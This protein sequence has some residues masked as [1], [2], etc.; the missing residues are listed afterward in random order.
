M[1]LVRMSTV[2]PSFVD[3]EI[4]LYAPDGAQLKKGLDMVSP[5]AAEI[6]SD[7]LPVSGRYTVLA[8]D[9]SS[10][11][12]GDYQIYTQ[13]LNNPQ[14]AT[15]IGFGEA[16]PGSIDF[17]VKADTYTFDALEGDVVLVRMTTVDPSQ[18]DAEIVLYAPDGSQLKNGLDMVSP[19]AAEITSSPLPASGRYTVLARDYSSDDTG[20]YEIYIQRLNNPQVTSPIGFGEVLAGSLEFAV[21]ADSYTFD[22]LEGDVVLARMTTVS[23]SPVD[24]EILLYAPNGSLLKKS[25]DM[26]SPGAAEITSDPLP[27]N[28]RYTV[29]ARDYSSDDIGDYTIQLRLIIG[30]EG[31]LTVDPF[32]ALNAS[33]IEGEPFAQS[34]ITYNLKNIGNQPIA[35]T[36]DKVQTWLDLS[37]SGGTLAAGGTDSVTVSIN[38]QAESL[39]PGAYFDTLTF[40][41][42]TESNRVIIRQA[43]LLVKT[44]EG[45]LVVS[46]DTALTAAGPRHGPFT[47]STMTF[48]LKNAGSTAL[49]WKVSKTGHW[50]TLSKEQGALNAG[51]TVNVQVDIN[52]AAEDFAWGVYK[53]QLSF[54][55]TTTGSGDAIWDVTLRIEAVPSAISCRLSASRHCVGRTAGSFRPDHTGAQPGGGLCGYRAA[56]SGRQRS[57]PLGGGQ[58]FGAVQLCSWL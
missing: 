34:N 30:S 20:D 7:P 57:S 15:P 33:G 54:V 5:G 40:T 26:V 38:A 3:A 36:L 16:H 17:A 22:A 1:V 13:R 56:G 9:Y 41:N 27:A 42:A 58:R 25:L 51:D 46:P 12:T 39:S 49:N 24:A 4:V 48:T 31:A 8:R 14:I 50:L 11:D 35:W 18:V 6:A 53:D 32:E 23:P 37:K 47:P 10:D 2:N 52:E 55:N 44:P 43:T 45:A 21:K 19:G 29:L 28:G